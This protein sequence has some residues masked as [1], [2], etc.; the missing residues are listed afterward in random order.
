MSLNL[1]LST[2]L[3]GLLTTQRGLDVVAHNIANMNTPD[4]T[5]KLMSPESRVLAGAGVGIQVT[6]IQRYVDEGLVRDVRRENG[7]LAALEQSDSYLTRLQSLFGDIAANSSVS[8]LIESFSTSLDSI[9]ADS[10]S[11]T[12]HWGVVQAA[13][14]MVSSFNQMTTQIQDLRRQ[15]DDELETAVEEIN[16]ELANI[17]DLNNKIALNSATQSGVVDLMDKR[18][19]AVDRLS[20]LMDISYFARSDNMLS[21]FTSSGTVLV[22]NSAATLTH[23]AVSQ[24]Q[25][26]LNV[27]D[28]TV[29]GVKIGLTDIT[30]EITSGKVQALIEMRDTVLPNIQAEIDRLAK[31]LQ[32]EVNKA[33]NRGVAFPNDRTQMTGSRTFIDSSTQTVTMSGGDVSIALFDTPGEQTGRTTLE[34][35]LEDGGEA[36]HGPWT[37]DEVA[38]NLDAWLDT[39]LGAGN[40][41]TVSSEGKLSITIPPSQGKTLAFKDI[42]STVFDT[43]LRGSAT[44]AL[45]ITGTLTFRDEES[46]V[47]GSAITVTAAD[48]LTTLRDKINNATTGVTGA[49][50]ELVT[51]TSGNTY[52]RVTSTSGDPMTLDDNAAKTALGLIPSGTND[53]QDVSLAFDANADGTTDQTIEG[54]SYFFGLND[55]FD[56]GAETS[57]YE[58]DLQSTTFT[59]SAATNLSFEDSTGALGGTVTIP[60]GSTLEEIAAQINAYAVTH[61]SRA[62]TTFSG[63][64]VL[65]AIHNGVSVATLDITGLTLSQIETQI[66]LAANSF[67]DFGITAAVVTEGSQSYLRIYDAEGDTLSFQGTAIGVDTGQL[68]FDTRQ[69]VK[70]NVV[71]EGNGQRLQLLHRTSTELVV[72]GTGV[73]ELGIEPGSVGAAG[74]I[75]VRADIQLAPSLISRGSVDF[76]SDT[77]RYVLSAGSNLIAQQL[78]QVMR[79]ETGFDPA[80]AIGAARASFQSYAG[81]IIAQTSGSTDAVRTQLD[82][83]KNLTESLSFERSSV[84]CVNIDEEISNLIVYQQSY[85]ASARVI[86]TVNAMLEVLTGIVR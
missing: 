57:I 53:A 59:T 41:A 36:P 24:Y 77:G 3:S 27:G 42:D 30:S 80:G 13:D 72:T 26:W 70:A 60:S 4:Y 17:A 81:T 11:S 1:A 29:T 7:K 5:R 58:S 33:H 34:T 44:A 55:F 54:F 18:D 16:T 61:D 48:T 68:A 84:S 52:L 64:G 62:S 28:G 50:A 19:A 15:A 46:A 69:Q 79:D 45:G 22:D 23:N 38:S 82:Y 32:E 75:E 20:K 43:A 10:A 37:I 40:Y 83:Q 21:V 85:A 63:S 39:Q 8:H 47:M 78:A 73:S 9:A 14:N 74:I 6:Q 2:A 76:D 25:P 35:I 51:D 31:A 67:D 86:S 56:D 49:V 65:N 12:Q 66:N 71:D